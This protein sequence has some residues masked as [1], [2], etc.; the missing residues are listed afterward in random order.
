[1]PK[2]RVFISHSARGDDC[3]LALLTL[4]DQRLRQDGFEV[5]LDL[6]GARG[7]RF[8]EYKIGTWLDRCHAAIALVTT[9]ALASHYVKF[10]VSNL[11][12]RW[13]HQG[14]VARHVS[15]AAG[16]GRPVPRPG[17]AGRSSPPPR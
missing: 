1:M 8:L 10:E 14:G 17:P 12:H 11:L 9:K 15:A 6:E 3:A 16:A 2:P 4:L 5:L 13:Q 7:R